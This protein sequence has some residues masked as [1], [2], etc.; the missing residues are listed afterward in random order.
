MKLDSK[1][2]FLEIYRIGCEL[3]GSIWMQLAAN[4]RSNFGTAGDDVRLPNFEVAHKF[5]NLNSNYQI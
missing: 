2:R 3:N 4:H 5:V 1:A